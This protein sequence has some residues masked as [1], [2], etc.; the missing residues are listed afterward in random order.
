VEGA[1][2]DMRLSDGWYGVGVVLQLNPH[3]DKQRGRMFLGGVLDFVSHRI[4]SADH[5]KSARLLSQGFAHLKVITENGGMVRGVIDLDA[6]RI[7]PY[8][9]RDID[10]V[11]LAKAVIG[12]YTANVEAGK[13]IADYP[14]VSTWGYKVPWHLADKLPRSAKIA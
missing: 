14:V 7:R 1:F 12:Y 9:C 5:L 6:L 13:S 10:Y 4:P 2:W 3:A 11:P 8:I